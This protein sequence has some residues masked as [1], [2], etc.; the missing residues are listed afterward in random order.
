L[1]IK[2]EFPILRIYGEVL[3]HRYVMPSSRNSNQNGSMFLEAGTTPILLKELTFG[4]QKV[5]LKCL[6]VQVLQDPIG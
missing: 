6:K 3:F 4:E 1:H 5:T 2:K